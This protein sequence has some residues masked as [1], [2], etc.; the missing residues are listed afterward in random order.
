MR[1]RSKLATVLSVEDID[2]VLAEMPYQIWER[3]LTYQANRV[4][5]PAWCYVIARNIALRIL[6]G[7]R[8]QRDGHG[9][10]ALGRRADRQRQPGFRQIHGQGRHL[11]GRPDQG[12]ETLRQCG[13]DSGARRKSNEHSGP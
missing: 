2:D 8:G 9:R 6:R 4:P 13:A 12:P 3:R 1:L 7:R 11:G 5:F 10:L